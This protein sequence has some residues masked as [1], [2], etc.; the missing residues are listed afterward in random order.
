MVY[1]N[2][3]HSSAEREVVHRPELPLLPHELNL[4]EV[5]VLF[6]NNAGRATL[7]TNKDRSRHE[8][9]EGNVGFVG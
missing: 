5:R 9:G 4:M 2:H 3:L 7:R 8:G 1:T 6:A